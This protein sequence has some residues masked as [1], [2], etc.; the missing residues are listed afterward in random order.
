[1]TQS[2][3]SGEQTNHRPQNETKNTRPLLPTPLPRL[4]ML[5]TLE[6][7]PFWLET[8]VSVSGRAYTLTNLDCTGHHTAG[9]TARISDTI[10]WYRY[11]IK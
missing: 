8:A 2:K 5:R 9:R 3:V 4:Q 6:R 11:A 10:K 7:D 1:M